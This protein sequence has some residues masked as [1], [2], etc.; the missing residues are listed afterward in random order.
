M[1]S[2][3]KQANTAMDIAALHGAFSAWNIDGECFT[4]NWY[5]QPERMQGF[6]R[7]QRIE[8]IGE[9]YHESYATCLDFRLREADEDA[10]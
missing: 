10:A 3:G 9:A 4:A 1:E 7:D 6:A 2:F 5:D 8:V